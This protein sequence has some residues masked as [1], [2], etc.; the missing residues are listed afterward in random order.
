MR[1]DPAGICLV[2]QWRTLRHYNSQ[3][4]LAQRKTPR[5]FNPQ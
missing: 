3:F 4:I 5:D 1:T 2:A